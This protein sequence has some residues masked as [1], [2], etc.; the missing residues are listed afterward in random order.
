MLPGV[1]SR[2][3]VVILKQGK[4]IDGDAAY[5]KFG[6]NFSSALSKA[7]GNSQALR[8]LVELAVIELI[9]KLTKTPYWTCLGADPKG[10]D[11]S[12]SRSPTGTT[13]WPTMRRS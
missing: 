5:H 9:G 4:G 2:N 6:I 11:A 7:E 12:E 10:D 1:T 3:S 13:R 8:R